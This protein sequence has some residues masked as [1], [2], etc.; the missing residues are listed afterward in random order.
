MLE[1]LGT[2]ASEVNSHRAA[3]EASVTSAGSWAIAAE[4]HAVK[5]T[6]LA[7]HAGPAAASAQALELLGRQGEIGDA[8]GTWRLLDGQLEVLTEEIRRILDEAP[9]GPESPRGGKT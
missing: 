6:L 7:T 5:G 9:P 8:P 3:L 2:F 4:A 1:L